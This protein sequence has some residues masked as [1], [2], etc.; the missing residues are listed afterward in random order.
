MSSGKSSLGKKL[1]RLLEVDFIDLDNKI[2]EVEGK[3]ISQIFNQN[4]EAYF[5]KIEAKMLSS[6][7]KNTQAVVA[8]GGGTPCFGSNI[9]YINKVGLSLYLEVPVKVLLGRLKTKS[10]TRPL[11]AN[12]TSEELSIFV[13]EQLKERSPFYKQADVIFFSENKPRTKEL[14]K[15]L[16]LNSIKTKS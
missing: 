15:A 1:A 16:S 7:T 3:S 4:G 14:L 2:I 13:K 12:L 10:K 6:I 11:I 9:E 8:L 5:R